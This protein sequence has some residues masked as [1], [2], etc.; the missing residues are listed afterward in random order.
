MGAAIDFKKQLKLL[1]FYSFFYSLSLLMIFV[2]AV[3]F[4]GSLIGPHSAGYL[5]MQLTVGRHYYFPCI[6]LQSA[7][8]SI[9]GQ[10]NKMSEFCLLP[11]LAAHC[12][13]GFIGSGL[14]PQGVNGL[15]GSCGTVRG[16][17]GY[18]HR[19]NRLSGKFLALCWRVL[20]RN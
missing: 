15:K 12:A 19:G 4:G 3:G 5:Q 18:G 6:Y 13:F 9:S 14:L 7:L 8:F 10:A 20:L 1:F 11:L 16:I 2:V 17:W